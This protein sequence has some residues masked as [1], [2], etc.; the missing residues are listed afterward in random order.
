MGWL[1]VGVGLHTAAAQAAQL[2]DFTDLVKANESAV[3]NISTVGEAPSRMN[4]G[5]PRNDQLEEFFRRLD[6]RVNEITNRVCDPA[7]WAADLSSK[8][9]DTF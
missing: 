9:M 1:S 4:R 8:Q 6:R 5:G 2:P 3:V 7:R